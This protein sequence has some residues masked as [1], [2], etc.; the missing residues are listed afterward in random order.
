M[1]AKLLTENGWKTVA[2]KSKIK[3]CGLQRA[4]SAYERL[5][6]D[7][8]AEKLKAV[9]AVIQVATAQKKAKDAAT[10]PDIAKYLT[11]LIAAA[12]AEQRELTQAKAAA[13]KADAA[14]AKK[15]AAESEEDE[16]E[17][18]SLDTVE[19]VKRALITL[20]TSKL[21]YYFIACDAKPY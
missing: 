2:Q 11:N 10:V 6:D 19:K 14:A 21:P 15:A 12:Q 8:H 20:K 16:A 18:E 5:D 3:D 1:D 17:D 4:L 13:E 9:A 7:Q